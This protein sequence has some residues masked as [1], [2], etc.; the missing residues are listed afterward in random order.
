[1]HLFYVD[2]PSTAR[3]FFVF[4]SRKLGAAKAEMAES[5][6]T[7]VVI[8]SDFSNAFK[9]SNAQPLCTYYIYYSQNQ[10]HRTV[11]SVKCTYM[12]IHI[13]IDSIDTSLFGWFV[14]CVFGSS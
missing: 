9:C 2:I 6:E 10:I 1:M 11:Y 3:F 5:E 8:C 14:S 4:T 13:Q 7:P 12:Y